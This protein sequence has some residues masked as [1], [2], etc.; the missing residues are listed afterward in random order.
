MLPAPDKIWNGADDDGSG[1]VAVLSIAE[2]LAKA[3][4]R[5]KRSTLFVWHCGE[6]KGLWGS[7]YWNKFP[8]VDVKKVITQ[9]NIDMIGRSL[10][11]NNIIKCDPRSNKPC[12]EELSK[13]DEIYVIGAEM[14]SS[15]LGALQKA[16]TAPISISGTT[17]ATTTRTIRTSSFSVRTT[18]IT[19]TTAYRS[20]SGS[21]AS[22]RIITSRRHAR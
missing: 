19:R 2:A 4:S 21:T 14:M 10:D 6:E 13:A 3:P 7:E 11:P 18:L 17:P 16:R 8:T 1:T 15:V 9:L 12:N 20:F 5:P 22:T